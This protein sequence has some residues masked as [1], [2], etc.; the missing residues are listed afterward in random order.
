MAINT[1]FQKD[2][3]MM[4]RKYFDA[5]KCT[6]STM[7]IFSVFYSYLRCTTPSCHGT[8]KFDMITKEVVERFTHDDHCEPNH[9]ILNQAMFKAAL[10]N[11]VQ[12]GYKNL[13]DAYDTLA[14]V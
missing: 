7:L 14:L 9:E 8:A 3:V 10:K 4:S 6:Y 5:K 1:E 13:K 2:I 12:S 11:S